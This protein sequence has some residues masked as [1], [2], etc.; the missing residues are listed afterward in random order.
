[1]NSVSFGKIVTVVKDNSVTTFPTKKAFWSWASTQEELVI[2]AN[3]AKSQ[4]LNK[5]NS[6]GFEVELDESWG[7]EWD[8]RLIAK[9]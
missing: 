5:L 3:T 4:I 7:F 1:M 2:K 6:L 9:K 8:F